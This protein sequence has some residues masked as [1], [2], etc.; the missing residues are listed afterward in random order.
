M[1]P[2]LMRQTISNWFRRNFS[3]P[4]A[5]GLFFFIVIAFLLF[6]F[7]S[8]LLMPVLISVVI[9][10]LLNSLVEWGL[11]LRLPRVLAVW[12]V[13]FL[14]LGLML[15]AVFALLPIL[16]RQFSNLISELPVALNRGQDWLSTFAQH[17]PSVFSSDPVAR[18]AIA[19]KQQSMKIGQYILSY[20]LSGIKGLLEV[21]VYLVLVPLLVFFFL[22]DGKAITHWI[23]RYLPSNRG[24]I[25]SVWSEVHQKIGAYVRSRVLEMLI[26]AVISVVAFVLLGM[27][28]AFLI[29]ICVGLS[30]IVPYIG[31]ILVTVPVFFIGL[32]QWGFSPHFGY[33]L[34]A[35]A[36]I[37][38]IDAN[39]LFPL[40]FS[41]TMN[42]HPIVIILSV[43]VFGGIWGFWG[44]FF[45][46]PLAALVKA[47]LSAWPQ[48]KEHA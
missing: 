43:L 31:A 48:V 38:A 32:M 40:L 35:Y 8:D 7:F 17:H 26:V 15:I 34:L 44:V 16:W 3:D 45:A 23:S 6:E 10:Y 27:Q 28:Y 21:V 11:T 24:L 20:S 42:L 18:I 9:A 33:L 36:V 41:E 19:V 4:E 39:V 14:F 13:Y 37:I 47:I 29:G 1:Q 25:H 5:L 46:I 12:L 2:S 22:K 30:V